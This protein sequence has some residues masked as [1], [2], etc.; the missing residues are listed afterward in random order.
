MTKFKGNFEIWQSE[1][2]LYIFYK[3][4]LIFKKWFDHG[5]SYLFDHWG[6]THYNKE[7]V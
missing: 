6:L 7:V 3:G 4:D 2:E 5:Y 1:N